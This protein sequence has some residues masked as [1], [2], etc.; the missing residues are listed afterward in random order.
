[1]LQKA[2][3][4][5]DLCNGQGG[6]DTGTAHAIAFATTNDVFV[7]LWNTD[8]AGN[9]LGHRFISMREVSSEASH[10]VTIMLQ[11]C[12]HL[13]PVLTECILLLCT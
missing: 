2:G 13:V 11:K 9:Y 7:I 3:A 12:E 6:Y 8:Q 10:A 5:C 1:M 4:Y